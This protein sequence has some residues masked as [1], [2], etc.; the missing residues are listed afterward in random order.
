MDK[1]IK[2]K[3]IALLIIAFL[4]AINYAQFAYI[5]STFLN[6]F[7]TLEFIGIIFFITYVITFFAINKYPHF[8]TK[9]N[10]YRTIIFSILL[11]ILG[12]IIFLYCKNPLLIILAFI[13]YIV[14]T[15]LIWINFDIFLEAYTSNVAT[16]KV[17]GLYYTI[18]NLGWVCSP[19]L[20]GRILETI[21]FDWI[22]YLVILSA[23]LLLIIIKLFFSDFNIKY[24][25]NH[26]N[27]KNT[28]ISVIKDKN[29]ERI[30]FIAIL[31]QIF[32]ATM[33]IY[34][35]IYLSQY[36][37]LT[38]TQIG[39]IFT[40]MLLPFVF[41]QYPAGYLADKFWGEKEM[42]TA[43]LVIM[44]ISS[45]SIFF[46]DSNSMLLWMFILFLSRIGASLTEIMRDTYFFKK[47]NVE[48]VHLINAFRS[49][50]PLAYIITPIISSILLYFLPF[51]YIF[52]ILGLF[53]TSGLTFSLTI[54][55]TK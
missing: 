54:R 35:P 45:I 11:D 38:W 21:G 23:I 2:R 17:R 30:F 6:Q 9:F 40:I 19:F 16:G 32:Y 29:M 26:F 39:A 24:E 53:L 1:T 28:A 22:F 13:F 46:I 33:V 15:N 55:D 27:L 8:I 43:G 48:N 4:I 10:N 44:A 12:I 37:G 47:V 51:N 25:R 7:F 49:T 41:L 14:S 52:L 18:Y 34:M 42:L 3:M 50:T 31:L 20:A 36:M 5:E